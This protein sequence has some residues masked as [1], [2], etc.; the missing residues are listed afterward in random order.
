MV[1]KNVNKS[2]QRGGETRSSLFLVSKGVFKKHF[3]PIE[4]IINHVFCTL[5]G[6][7]IFFTL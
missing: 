1:K 4:A 2:P 7:S 5:G 6:H 3:K